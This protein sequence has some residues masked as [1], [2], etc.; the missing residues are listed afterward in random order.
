MANTADIASVTALQEKIAQLED[1]NAA[2]KTSEARFR[3]IAATMPG[4]IYQFSVRGGVWTVDYISDRI[5]DIMGV[6][7]A[8]VME[9]LSA[10][11]ARLHPDDVPDYIASIEKVLETLTPW[12]YEGKFIKPNGEIGWWQGSAMPTQDQEGNLVFDGVLFDITDRHQLEV[13]LRQANEHLEINVKERTKELETSI[14]QLQVEI[15]QRQKTE[16]NL[17]E[18]ESKF[19]R[20]ANNLPGM[21]YQFRLNPDGSSCFPYVSPFAHELY[22]LEPESIQ[23]DGSLILNNV[24]PDDVEQHSNSIAE[25]AQTFQPWNSVWRII[26]PSGKLKWLRGSSRPERQADGSILW[27][28]LI[29]DVTI[30]LTAETELRRFR[31][32]LESAIDAVGM[33]TPQGVHIYQN[34]AFTDLYGYGTP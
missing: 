23:R 24:H 19:Q 21:I 4:V 1:E 33:A 2:L 28:G 17:R 34:Q 31:Q 25:S 30:Q 13:S 18:I 15:N 7:A 10:F 3:S 9:N 5:Y 6:T 22:E 14:S 16:T 27:D 8:A 32:V 12:H 29:T 11:V 26:T 20:L